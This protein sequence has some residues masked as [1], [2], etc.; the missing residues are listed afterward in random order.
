MELDENALKHIAAQLRKPEGDDG[1]QTGERMNVGN[2]AMNL[3]TIAQ[4]NI[5][6]NDNLLEIGMGNGYFVTQILSVDPTVKYTGADY[7]EIM[8]EE[9]GMLNKQHIADGQAAFV[10]ANADKLPFADAT[11]NKAFTINTLY[12]WEDPKAVLAELRRVLT[13]GGKLLVTIRPKSI[14]Q[15]YPFTQYGFTM[16]SPQEA[17]VLLAE[18]GFKVTDIITVNEQEKEVN[19]NGVMVKPESV[20]ICAEVA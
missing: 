17:G 11:F 1:R 16:Y 5:S 4:L 13:P 20:I 9:A 10:T 19:F 8:V 6:A 18:N 7:S 15:T 3:A 14:M 2:E 12:F